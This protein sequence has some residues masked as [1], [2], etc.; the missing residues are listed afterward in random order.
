MPERWL[1]SARNFGRSARHFE[2]RCLHDGLG[3]QK[4]PDVT[5]D[6]GVDEP[7]RCHHS[8]QRRCQLAI[9]DFKHLLRLQNGFVGKRLH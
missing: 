3:D 2:I 6:G 4:M 5:A 7:Q 9:E 8:L 1:L